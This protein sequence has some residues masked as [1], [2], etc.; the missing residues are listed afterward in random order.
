MTLRRCWSVQLSTEMATDT[1]PEQA[2]RQS[3]P[4]IAQ[5]MNEWRTLGGFLVILAMTTAAAFIRPSDQRRPRSQPTRFLLI[6][7]AGTHH[8]TSTLEGRRSISLPLRGRRR[9]LLRCRALWR[10]AGWSFPACVGNEQ[11]RKPGVARLVV[12]RCQ[13]GNASRNDAAEHT[14]TNT[15]HIELSI[16]RLG[17]CHHLEI[18]WPG[19]TAVY[20]ST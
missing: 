19:V 5:E 8:P 16:R 15:R 2:S 12:G 7:A 11:A 3:P 13:S 4:T 18:G 1:C 10:K 20:R 14:I 9:S 6:D 17:R